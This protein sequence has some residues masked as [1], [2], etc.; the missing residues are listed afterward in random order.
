MESVSY[1]R[2]YILAVRQRQRWVSH[3]FMPDATYLEP[4]LL[5]A[6]IATYL[7]EQLEEMVG[8]LSP[9]R[10]WTMEPYI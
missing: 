5:I 9:D 10:V 3:A 7:D 2:T 4:E 6:E 8:V 1:P